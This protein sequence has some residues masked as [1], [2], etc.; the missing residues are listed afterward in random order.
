[1]L[2]KKNKL[3]KALSSILFG[4]LF[5]SLF[6]STVTFNAFDEQSEDVIELDGNFDSDQS[7]IDEEFEKN[8]Q[9]NIL[10]FYDEENTESHYDRNAFE[11]RPIEETLK[12]FQFNS[13]SSVG[14]IQTASYNALTG[15][16]TITVPQFTP[17]PEFST[18]VMSVEPY[19]GLLSSIGT[20][21]SVIGGDGRT[22]YNNLVFPGN[23]IVKLYIADPWGGNWVGSGAIID[24]FHVLTAGHCAYIRE[25]GNNGW[26]ST[27]EVVPAMDT[28]DNPSDP[29]GSAWVTNMR[30]YTGWTVSGDSQHDWAVLTLDRNVGFYTGWMGRTTAG[31]SSSI[32]TGTMNVAGYPTDLSSGNRMY[33][34]ADA[35]DGA[36]EYNHFY[37]ADTAG[38]MSGGPV[39]RYDGANRYIMTVHAY[40]R[41]GVDSNYGT[42]L[43]TDKYDRIFTWLGSDSAPT[44]KADLIDR[45]VS[46]AGYTPGSVTAGITSFSVHNEIRNVGTASSGNYV[47][48]YYASTNTFISTSDYYI[49]TSTTESTGAFETDYASWSGTFPTI[50]GG[51]YYIG[52]IIDKDDV[53]D[54]FDEANNRAYIST[55]LSVTGL[56]PPIS[57]IE[58][59]VRDSDTSAYISSTYVKCYEA[60]TAILVDSGYTNSN[61]FYNITN[62]AVGDY[63][64]VVSKNGYVTQTKVDTIDNLVKGYDD[65]Y[66]YFYLVPRPPDSSWIEVTVRDSSTSNPLSSAYVQIANMTS[67]I[68][69][70][71]GYTNGAGFYNATGLYIG[72]YEVTV[73]KTGY[74]TQTKQNY[75]NWNYDDDYLTFYL[76]QK[77]VDSG[78]IE[79]RVYNET[80]GPKQSVLVECWHDNGTFH[81]SGYT[82]SEGFYNITGLVIGW[83]VVNV[84]HVGYYE[85]TKSDYINWRG[86]DDYLSFYLANLPPDS[87]YIDVSVYDSVTY[88]GIG[89]VYVVTTNV[90]SGLEID[91]GYT[92]SS[93][94]YSVTGLTV[95]WYSIEVSRGGYYTETKQTYINWAGDDDYL[96]YYLDEMPPDSGYIEVLVKDYDTSLPIANAYV[97]CNYYNGTYFTSGYTDSS[98]FFNVTGLYIGWYTIDVSHTDY[99][100]YSKDDYINWNGDDDYLYF[101]LEIKPPGWI[102]V[103]VYD[104]FGSNPIQNAYVRCFNTTS[105]DLVDEGYTDSSGFYNIT[106]LLIGWWTVNVS[107]PTFIMQSQDDYINWRGDDDYLYFYLE[108]KY[109]PL[110]GSVAI[111][112]DQYS[113]GLNVTEPILVK[114]GIPYI[115]YGSQDFGLVDLSPYKKVIIS[116]YQSQ[117]FYDR[118]GGNVTWFETY[119]NNGGILQLH[120]CDS[121][122]GAHWYPYYLMP[123][124]LNKTQTYTNNVS[125]N[126]PLHPV[127]LNPWLIEDDELDGWSSSTHG[128]FSEYPTGAIEILIDSDI[129]TIGYSN[130]VLIE[131]PFGTGFIIASMQTLEWNDYFNYTKL[132]ENLI[133]YD[134]TFYIA[135]LTVTAPDNADVWETGYSQYIYWDSIGSISNVNIELYKDGSFVQTIVSGTT[136][137][138]VFY[139]KVPSGL[140]DSTQY[141]IKITD[142]SDHSTFDFSEN[143][144]IFTDAITVTLPDGTTLWEIETSQYIYWTSTGHIAT[145]NIE[146]YKEDTYVQTIVSGTSNDG[147]F[148]WAI[149]A[150]LVYSTQY[151]I[152]IIDVSNSSIYD[153]SDYFELYI[154]SITVTI[155]DSSTSWLL[156]TTH[157]I[158]WNSTGHIATVNIELYLDGSLVQAIVSGTSN[159]GVYSWTIPVSLTASTLYQIKITDA[160]DPTKFAFSD[161]FEIVGFPDDT[162]DI[163]GYNLVLLL[164]FS[165]GISMILLKK[166][167]NLK[168][169]N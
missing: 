62:L 63:D 141:Q 42:R 31:S 30:S 137:D 16:E 53:V 160:S 143:F 96:T 157:D 81:G 83:Y 32:Y 149:P 164:L 159:D 67:G 150:G 144:E 14:G 85:Q 108:M 119:V 40:G 10:E 139:W 20:A 77:P 75:I 87:G 49:G 148:Y 3:T 17:K 151:Q 154:D 58:V 93:G 50:P 152:K 25:G 66:L 128:T 146:L 147:E 133:L 98:G 69:I 101:Y 37:W 140:V 168:I 161:N 46:Y 33:W 84:S 68:V 79:V 122:T 90:S 64:V 91:W 138:G 162:P 15:I 99:G 127:L 52:W 61:G 47:V 134:P 60:G 43:N 1:M 118:L 120:A 115:V 136:N 45:G 76:V 102:E 41:G 167:V 97:I 89:S 113:W 104:E 19:A 112:Q 129:A 55:P 145:V 29:Y 54:E 23:T 21:E 103:R 28:S 56:N 163:P 78:Y 12:D 95:G 158:Y 26:A 36:T 88:L 70:Q 126:M 114:Y 94:A 109:E 169:N 38:G 80:G 11:W 5:I 124:G 166:K 8:E 106:G 44:D 125:I 39:W 135:N 6:S 131:F 92:A 72:W 107:C 117:T 105:G 4:I 24:N 110:T 13:E 18:D 59:R 27:I 71:A 155:P 123:G 34:D 7:S 51:N 142:S 130:P 86:D 65:D 111:F 153:Y 165:V 35:G 22:V 100:G 132:L 121:N 82:N 57:Y 73:S 116:S 9:V 74:A 156:F 48:H 2:K